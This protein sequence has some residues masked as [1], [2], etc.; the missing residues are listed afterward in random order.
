[1]PLCFD[2]VYIVGS[3]IE[4]VV[5]EWSDLNVPL[6]LPKVVIYLELSHLTIFSL[7]S[8]VLGRLTDSR[9]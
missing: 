4:N 2:Y 7:V 6:N 8:V 5:H 9:T 1:M 3:S